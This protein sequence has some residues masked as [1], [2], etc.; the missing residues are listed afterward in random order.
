M[1][2]FIQ[3]RRLAAACCLAACAL[4]TSLSAEKTY[5]LTKATLREIN[6]ALE[7]GNLTS[8]RLVRLY[9][10]RIEAFDKQGPGINAVI[11]LNP[12]AL[13]EARALDAERTATGPRS[14]IHG[15][16]VVVK[17]LIDVEGMV[18]TAGF[19]PFGDPVA[20][21]DSSVAAR[22]REAGGI[23]LAKVSTTNW[24]GQGFDD[25]HP[26]GETLNPYNTGHSPGGSSNGSGA[27][28]AASFATLAIGTDTSV[29][30]QSPASQTSSVGFVG[31]YGMVSRAGI[32]PRGATQD[33]PGPIT[34]SVYEAAVLYSIISGWDAEDFTTFHGLG[35]HP[36]S[37]WG[38]LLD[39]QGLEGKRIGVLR[40]MIPEGPEFAEA[41]ALFEQAIE[42]LREAGAQIVD[43]VLTGNPNLA[44]DTSQP[45]LRTAEYEKIHYTDAYLARLGANAKYPDTRAMM[46]AVGHERFSRSMQTAIHLEHPSVSRDYQARHR[47]RQAFIRLIEDTRDRYDLDAFILPFSTIPPAP[48]EQS[49]NA[50]PRPAGSGPRP[51]V[52]SLSSSLGL[53]AAVVPAGYI[54]EDLPIALQFIGGR[55][56]DL[57]ILKIAHAYE[58]ASKRRKPAASTPPLP[59]ETFR[60]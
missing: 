49:G 15:I 5:D 21:R 24:F 51:G 41:V 32:I 6:G 13:E 16:P 38:A 31:T 29:S 4:T 10:A 8:E 52:N 56:T 35:H 45:R 58:Q 7:S 46:D 39:D 37:D 25:T 20:L 59:N 30:V 11:S 36:T 47:A 42:N 28:I 26:I 1:K 12:N 48:S 22:I 3:H 18:T 53:P 23:L 50:L 19:T 60:F 57:E 33:R 27:A 2:R 34:K 40:E 54:G 17:D 14:A 44:L 43:P 55:Y 9:L